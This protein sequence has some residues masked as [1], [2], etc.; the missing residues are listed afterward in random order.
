MNG[1]LKVETKV[2]YLHHILEVGTLMKPPCQ[3]EWE[4]RVVPRLFSLPFPFT[5]QMKKFKVKYQ[6]EGP[7]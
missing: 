6:P 4:E 2:A 7:K 5:L 3:R 1:C